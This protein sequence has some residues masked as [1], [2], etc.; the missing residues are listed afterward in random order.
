MK[1]SNKA[2]NIYSQLGEDGIIE[3]IFPYLKKDIQSL[4]VIEFG[5]WDGVH[6]SNTFNLICQGANA[7]LI[8][9]DEQRFRDLLL[10]ASKYSTITPLN[11]IVRK[12]GINSLDNILKEVPKIKNNEIDVLSIDVDNRDNLN[13][14]K[15]TKLRP[16]IVLIEIDTRFLPFEN[17]E[18]VAGYEDDS[19]YQLSNVFKETYNYTNKLGYE[20][21]Y[22]SN[23]MIFVKNAIYKNLLENYSITKKPSNLF[24]Y[25]NFIKYRQITRKDLLIL[26][27]K[28]FLYFP[29]KYFLLKMSPQAVKNIYL[30]KYYYDGLNN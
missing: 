25:R 10:T 15:S 12:N 8:E 28:N 21:V 11:K 6:L 1:L 16:Q 4:E 17:Y 7:V 18:E 2:K 22:C 20:L 13:I 30:D 27:L 14:W 3:A 9:S 29:L 19:L 23:N 26:Y 24:D 5:A